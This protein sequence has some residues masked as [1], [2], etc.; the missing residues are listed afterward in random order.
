M[1]QIKM[2]G[3]SERYTRLIE[4]KNPVTITVL[5]DITK[6]SDIFHSDIVECNEVYESSL[7][8]YKVPQ[9]EPHRLMHKAYIS[10]QTDTISLDVWREIHYHAS[11]DNW[12]KAYLYRI[13]PKIADIQEVTI[14]R[15]KPMNLS[16]PTYITF[17]LI[18][19]PTLII[20]KRVIF[21]NEAVPLE[22][23]DFYDRDVEKL[24]SEREK[25]NN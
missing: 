20:Y 18:E 16:E 22:A 25:Y 15:F 11:I 2:I 13:T 12:H 10:M 23:Y 8:D 24:E 1:G 19:N 9:D 21:H 7:L 14:Y 3:C 4:K 5:A 6:D 17:A